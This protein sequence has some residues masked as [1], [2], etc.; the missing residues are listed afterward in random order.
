MKTVKIAVFAM[1][2]VVLLVA[3]SFA[4]DAGKGKMLFEDPKFAGGVK[5]CS[6]CH[7]GGRGLEKAGEK[8]EFH[9]MGKT[10][11]TLEEAVNFCIVNANKGKALD[12]NS[13]QM[14]DVVAFIKSLKPKKQS[15]PGY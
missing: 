15:A 5:S 14:K 10:Q 8:K 6:S 12:P 7:P 9:V 3:L 4:G 11:K 2:V 1:S 13:E